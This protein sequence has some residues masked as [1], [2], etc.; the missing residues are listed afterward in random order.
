MP[1]LCEAPWSAATLSQPWPRATLLPGRG[2]L[3][4]QIT[5]AQLQVF[6]AKITFEAAT[7]S[8]CLTAATGS[9]HSTV[10]RTTET[11]GW[12]DSNVFA[13]AERASATGTSVFRTVQNV[14]AV[15]K[16]VSAVTTTVSGVTEIVSAAVPIV[17]ATGK[18]VSAPNQSVSVGNPIVSGVTTIVSADV[19][20]VFP[21]DH[22]RVS[23]RPNDV[24]GQPKRV[25]TRRNGVSAHP[26]VRGTPRCFAR[27]PHL[28]AWSFFGA[29]VLGFGA[30]HRH[31]PN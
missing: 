3:L 7:G 24:S 9:P 26:K 8:R 28:E 30:S 1:R 4:L 19:E 27:P 29:W 13:D 23:P 10:L 18:T 6:A 11:L 14:F 2:R 25:S 15:A 5:L 16:I 17:S 21:S 12:S 20:T 22:K 31:T